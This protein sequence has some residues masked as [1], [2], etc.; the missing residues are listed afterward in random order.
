M[1]WQVISASPYTAA[2]PDDPTTAKLLVTCSE[3]PTP[4]V[5]YLRAG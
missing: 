3:T 5:Y 1:T 4:W 2:G